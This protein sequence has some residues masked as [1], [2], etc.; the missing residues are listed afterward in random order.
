MS[1]RAYGDFVPTNVQKFPSKKEY[2]AQ[3]PT[4]MHND[5]YAFILNGYLMCVSTYLSQISI[6]RS[7][8]SSW[9][10]AIS[11]QYA[12]MSSIR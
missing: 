1:K 3:F 4:K 9:S 2:E 7:S 8:K 6:P 5:K 11:T 12:A 10:V